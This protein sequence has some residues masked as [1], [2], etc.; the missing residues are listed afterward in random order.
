MQPW[1]LTIAGVYGLGPKALDPGKGPAAVPTR[2][3]LSLPF[4]HADIQV[5]IPRNVW[6]Q[7]PG[8]AIELS[9]NMHVTKDLYALLSSAV[10]LKRCA[11]MPVITARDLRWRAG[12]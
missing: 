7:G 8:T 9:G 10:A 2:R 11:A 5:D 3:D 12:T 4:V 6:L 1:E